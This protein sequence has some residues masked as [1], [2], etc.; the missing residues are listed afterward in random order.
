[1]VK[2]DLL[3]RE[4]AEAADLNIIHAFFESETGRRM[5]KAECVRR[6]VPFNYRK[7]AHEIMDNMQPGHDTLLIQGVIDCFFEEE[8]Q[9][10]IVDYKTDYVDSPER[11]NELVKLYQKQMNLYS[12]ALEQITGKPVRERIL[13]FLSINQAIKIQH[14]GDQNGKRY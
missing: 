12:E 4:E 6:E 10:V 13:Y 14:K 5:R 11:V 8:G 9:W 1:M 2:R 3:T 7:K